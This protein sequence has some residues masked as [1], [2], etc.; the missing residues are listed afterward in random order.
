M[1]FGVLPDIPGAIFEEDK[2]EFYVI[3]PFTH[4]F[5]ILSLDDHEHW[6]RLNWEVYESFRWQERT[7]EGYQDGVWDVSPTMSDVENVLMMGFSGYHITS[8]VD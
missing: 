4:P 1:S 6:A 2:G 8:S 3:F 7:L 5:H